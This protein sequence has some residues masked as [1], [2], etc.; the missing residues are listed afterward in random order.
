[1]KAATVKRGVRMAK[2]QLPDFI[3]SDIMMPVKDGFTCCREIR[4]QQDRAYSYL[5]T[6]CKGGRCWMLHGSKIAERMI[7]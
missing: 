4:M 2:E 1:M 6:D 3:I 5:D 7:I